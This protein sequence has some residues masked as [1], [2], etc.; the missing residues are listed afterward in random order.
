MATAKKKG[1]KVGVEFD[2]DSEPIPPGTKAGRRV[3]MIDGEQGHSNQIWWI[4]GA[5][6][7]IALVLGI[8]IGR[9]F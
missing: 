8:F 5:V 4:V 6:V 9:S 7:I 1:V 3:R 2:C